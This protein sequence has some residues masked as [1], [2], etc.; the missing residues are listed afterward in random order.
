MHN[1]STFICFECK[2]VYVAL[3]VCV[4]IFSDVDQCQSLWHLSIQLLISSYNT[5]AFRIYFFG[6]LL[7]TL[8]FSFLFRFE[9][10]CSNGFFSA[11]VYVSAPSL[12]FHFAPPC[13]MSS[14]SKRVGIFTRGN[15]CVCVLVWL[16]GWQEDERCC[17]CM[18]ILYVLCIESML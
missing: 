14:I 1:I 10:Y 7:L 13:S 6:S 2:C 12:H 17:L 5:S 16:R 11:A 15:E 4:R 8:E 9:C 3:C 18:Y